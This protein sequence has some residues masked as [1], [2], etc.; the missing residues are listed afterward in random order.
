MLR[1]QAN[2]QY[3]RIKK[4]PARYSRRLAEQNRYQKERKQRDPAFSLERRLRC[5][6]TDLVRRKQAMKKA[7]MLT[8]LGCSLAELKRHLERQFTLGMTWLN[9]G[10]VWHIDHIIPCAKFDLTDGR[11]QRLCFHYLNLRPLRTKEECTE[12]G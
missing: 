3:A 8:M 7:S 12:A 4:D 2:R 10:R 6:L 11:Q 9:Y 1:D 5:R